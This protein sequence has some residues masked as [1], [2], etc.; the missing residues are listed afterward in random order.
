[1]PA[2]AVCAALA[3][4]SLGAMLLIE[5]ALRAQPVAG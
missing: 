1:V 3:C 2:L 4:V 5:R